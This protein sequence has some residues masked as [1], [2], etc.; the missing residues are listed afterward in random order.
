MNDPHSEKRHEMFGQASRVYNLLVAMLDLL[1]I[2]FIFTYIANSYSTTT[3]YRKTNI[4]QTSQVSSNLY[5]IREHRGVIKIL[6]IVRVLV[7]KLEI[8]V[9]LAIRATTSENIM[10]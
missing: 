7:K 10:S 9:V 1:R 3:K 8:I 6:N 2:I 4:L 5:F